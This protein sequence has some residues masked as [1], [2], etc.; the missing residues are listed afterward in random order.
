[1]AELLSMSDRDLRDIGIDR[2][3]ILRAVRGDTARSVY[4]AMPI[5]FAISQTRWR[6]R[7]SAGARYLQL[8]KAR[9]PFAG[10]RR[11]A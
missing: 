4:D 1:M 3:E 11:G 5:S 7:C 9:E 10:L 2:C 6:D 8:Q